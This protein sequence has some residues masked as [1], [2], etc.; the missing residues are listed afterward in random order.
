MNPLPTLLAHGLQGAACSGGLRGAAGRWGGANEPPCPRYPS[1]VPAEPPGRW[2]PGACLGASTPAL[3]DADRQPKGNITRHVRPRLPP[4]TAQRWGWQLA[5]AQ[6][7]ALASTCRRWD[8]RPAS[9]CRMK[10]IRNKDRPGSLDITPPPGSPG[11]PDCTGVLPPDAQYQSPRPAASVSTS[12]W[13]AWGDTHRLPVAG[14]RPA[15]R[16]LPL[17]LGANTTCPHKTAL[18]VACS[19]GIA[20]V[21]A[22]ERRSVGHFHQGRLSNP[23]LYC[24]VG[25]GSGSPTM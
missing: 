3:G 15:R 2:S 11:Y 10:Q 6:T 22:Q 12:P 20:L 13:P 18:G 8:V 9:Q 1:R 24:I 4:A 17:P 14:L 16:A 23:V 21:Q 5:R 19:R 7:H 25:V